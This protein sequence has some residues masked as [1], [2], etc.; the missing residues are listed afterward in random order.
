MS[1]SFE[2]E[3]A[4]EFYPA[5]SV[6]SE[7]RSNRMSELVLGSAGEPTDEEELRTPRPSQII[8]YEEQPLRV[9]ASTNTDSQ[10]AEILELLQLLNP[11]C[12]QWSNPLAQLQTEVHQLV[13]KVQALQA[14]NTRLKDAS[15]TSRALRK[16]HFES[17]IK[18]IQDV[19]LR[20]ARVLKNPPYRRG[21]VASQKIKSP[22]ASSRTPPKRVL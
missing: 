8:E 22:V 10:T 12:P 21:L 19:N 9:D 20:A 17:A 2:G 13:N 18:E 4:P 3:S 14:E 11:N 1:F 7:P 6:S 15:R 5:G 16:P